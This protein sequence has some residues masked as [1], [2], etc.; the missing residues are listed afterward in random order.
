VEIFSEVL[1]LIVRSSSIL[2]HALRHA[3]TVTS[4]YE[5]LRTMW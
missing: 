2:R 5:A 4:L 1:I 3:L